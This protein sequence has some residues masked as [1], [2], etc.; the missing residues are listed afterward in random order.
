MSKTRPYVLSFAGYDPSGGA[1][2]LADIKTFEK[3]KVYGMGICTALTVQ[4]DT[5]FESVNWISLEQ[6]KEQTACLLH[7]FSPTYC[8]IGLI[9]N[10]ATLNGLLEY[11]HKEI[12]GVKII[13]DPIL[14]A[15]AGFEFHAES[16]VRNWEKI[17]K[18]L[19]LITPNWNEMEALAEGEDVMRSAQK[20]SKNVNIFLKGG[21][22]KEELGRDYLLM[23]SAKQFNFR[24]RQA[25]KYGKH[26]SGCVLSASITANLAK[27]YS[28][29]KA[30]LKSKDY[31]STFLLSNK[32]HLGYHS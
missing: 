2:L 28:L 15:S 30:C 19:F 3:H 18:Q 10:E 8:K 1:G 21:H 22:N 11:L 24:P 26:G 31:I 9:E 17:W 27:G 13:F 20:M 16:S 5:E 23:Q 12:D 32:T 25:I 29:H 6:I 7:K 14:R 4:N